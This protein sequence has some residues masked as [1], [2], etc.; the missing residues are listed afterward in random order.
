[1]FGSQQKPGGGKA[2]PFFA[3]VEI[4]L[5]SSRYGK[6]LDDRGRAIGIWVHARIIKNKV[7]PPFAE[8]E[9]LIRFDSGVQKWPGVLETL[10]AENRVAVK[11]NKDFSLASDEFTDLKMGEV[12]PLANFQQ[13]CIDSKVLES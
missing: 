8:C 2:V 10:E 11:R 4:H 3:S 12:L 6:V 13:W 9:F 7:A 1:M 5:R